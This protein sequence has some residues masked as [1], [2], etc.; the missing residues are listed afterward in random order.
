MKT[1]PTSDTNML[2]QQTQLTHTLPH[3]HHYQ[4]HQMQHSTLPRDSVLPD[5]S[6]QHNQVSIAIYVTKMRW[7]YLFILVG[8]YNAS[9]FC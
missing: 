1:I 9:T 6:T 4:K 8:Y 3:P 2:L 5:I 7:I